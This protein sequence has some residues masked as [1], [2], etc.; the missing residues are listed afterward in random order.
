M[1][2]TRNTGYLENLIQYDASDN[3][4]I[5]TSVNPSY[6]V[7]LGGSLLGTSAVFSGNLSLQ[8]AVTRNIN[9]YDSSNTNINAQI[10]YDQISSNSGQLF[11]GT[12]NAGTFAT[13]LTI[14]N[15][16]KATF[17]ND[18]QGGGDLYF[19]KATRTTIY[20]T[21][22]NQNLHIKSNG[23]GTL[24]FNDDVTGNIAMVV[25]G[26]NVG[27][28]TTSPS[29]KLDVYASGTDLQTYFSQA[30]SGNNNFTRWT[31]ASGPTLIAGVVR[32]TNDGNQKANTAFIGTSNAY[33]FLLYSGDLERMRITSGGNIAI[34]NT[35]VNNVVA[36]RTILEL[37]GTSTALFNLSIGGS[38]L[39]YLYHNGTNVEVG[40]EA[41]GGAIEFN[42]AGSNRMRI[43]SGGEVSFI[44]TT[45][46]YVNPSTSYRN[47]DFG[48]GGWLYRDNSDV[49]LT[50]NNYYNTSGQWVAKYSYNQGV[51]ILSLA[52]GNFTWN[53]YDG[54]VTAGT[55]YSLSPRFLITSGG[56]VGIG[57]T[58]IS[59]E[60]L[61]INQTT[62]NF[63]AL[64]VNTT[65]VT[66]GQ[67]Y[68]L[69]IQAGT[70]SSDRSFG[71]YNQGGTTEYFKVSGDGSIANPSHPTTANAANVHMT[72]AGTFFRNTS[73]LKYKNTVTDYNKGLNIVNQL[74]PVYYKG[75][76]DGDK[77]FA[78]LIAEEVHD[79]GLTEFV[80]YAEDGS[81]DALAYQNM[82]ALLTKAIQEQQAQIEE[83]KSKL[84]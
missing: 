13:R 55:G 39:G 66:A 15:T 37:N 75:N 78:G 5:A 67:S 62:G 32:S 35:T 57:T 72:V 63:S 49:Y 44:P 73:S 9:F 43:R 61:T 31:R 59:N 33:D 28:G 45:W 64:L 82:V 30:S 68:G 20:P 21:T 65:G 1:G 52:G 3:V 41:S 54:N 47:M 71:V 10:Q 51:G 12:N 19:S 23:T 46:T 16:G 6:K 83:L 81:P 24:Q 84:A 58:S 50:S 8:G 53:S 17:S 69:T 2:A 7:T 80:Q 60:K 48:A 56:N 22:T 40:N 76:N 29:G 25:G 18:I 14:S 4:A 70:N 38:R 11:F 79:L 26:G 36:N 74:R 27:I 34:G 77:I 42:T